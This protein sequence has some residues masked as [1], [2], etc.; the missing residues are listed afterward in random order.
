MF[1]TLA[2]MKECGSNNT[3]S[4]FVIIGIGDV[5]NP[6]DFA[7]SMKLLLPNPLKSTDFVATSSLIS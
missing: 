5:I 6:L 1:G 7:K 3:K 2:K 4:K